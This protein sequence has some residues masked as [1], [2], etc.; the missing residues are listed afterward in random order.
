MPRYVTLPRCAVRAEDDDWY[1][2]PRETCVVIVD[3]AAPQA[4]GLLDETGA[5][6]YRLSDRGPLGFCR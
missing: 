2:P 1:Q 4:T 3:D 6:L 5:P